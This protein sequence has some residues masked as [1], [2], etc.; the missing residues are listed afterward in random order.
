MSR[1]KCPCASGRPLRVSVVSDGIYPYFKGGKEVRYHQLLGRVASC[2][3]EV[4]V[5][6]M[7]CWDGPRTRRQDGIIYSIKWR[8]PDFMVLRFVGTLVRQNALVRA[9]ARVRSLANPQSVAI[10]Q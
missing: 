8:N 2:D 7:K 10:S 4:T 3:T 1:P 9:H 5:H 6:T